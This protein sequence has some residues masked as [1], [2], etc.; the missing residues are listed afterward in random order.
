MLNYIYG[1]ATSITVFTMASVLD[2]NI[3][4]SLSYYVDLVLP[5]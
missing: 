1:I 5:F 3:P 2:A 4:N